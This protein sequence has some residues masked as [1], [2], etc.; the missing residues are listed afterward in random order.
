MENQDSEQV[1]AASGRPPSKLIGK[2]PEFMPNNVKLFFDV[3]EL[4]F[5][6]NKI[7][8]D[9]QRVTHVVTSLPT[10]VMIE[11]KD[12]ISAIIPDGTYLKIKTTIVSR[13]EKSSRKK[14]QLL[15]EKTEL[16]DTRPSHLFR[17]MKEL[18]DDIPE[19]TLIQMWL[20]KLPPSVN[21]S[22]ISSVD[23]ENTDDLIILA[24]KLFEVQNVAQISA[25]Q[26]TNKND[27][28]VERINKLEIELVKARE[29]QNYKKPHNKNPKLCFYHSKFKK[30]STRCVQPC[31]WKGPD[32]RK[33]NQEN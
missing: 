25:A 6:T 22:L 23:S 29:N 19:K 12:F 3:A 30:Q 17:K 10:E 27:E 21:M 24:D 11:I 14:L 15:L 1:A 18:S 4:F 8:S 31:N 28:L 33:Q 16:G 20:M 7:N 26:L 2:F 5:N 13:R 9:Q 32:A